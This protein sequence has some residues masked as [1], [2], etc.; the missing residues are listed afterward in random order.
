MFQSNSAAAVF[1]H[2]VHCCP[3]AK[4]ALAAAGFDEALVALRRG[5]DPHGPGRKS[6][7]CNGSLGQLR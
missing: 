4:S 6:R 3:G 2:R 7:A 5:I 1:K